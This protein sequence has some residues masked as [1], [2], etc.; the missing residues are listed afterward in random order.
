MLIFLDVISL[1]TNIPIDLTVDS[2]DNE[3]LSPTIAIF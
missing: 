3:T 2:F 1:F